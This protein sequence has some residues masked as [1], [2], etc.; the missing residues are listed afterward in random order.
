MD[1]PRDVDRWGPDEAPGASD[2]LATA[3]TALISQRDLIGRLSTWPWSTGTIRGFAT[4]L[5]I[6][7]AIWLI[8]RLLDRVV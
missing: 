7:V 4:T 8:T 5:L 2:R 3:Q 1:P 6:P